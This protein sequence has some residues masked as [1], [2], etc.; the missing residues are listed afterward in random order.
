[1]FNGAPRLYA[2]SRVGRQV[3]AYYIR[4]ALAWIG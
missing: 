4:Q 2:N 3:L 1:M